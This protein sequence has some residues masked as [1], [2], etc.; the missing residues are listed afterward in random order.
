M[1][2]AGF[3]AQG[4]TT[5]LTPFS[6]DRREPGPDDVEIDIMYCG[7]CHSDLHTARNEWG[8]TVYPI[9]PGH[10]IIGRVSRT[11]ANATAF[12]EGDLLGVAC[13]VDSCQHCSECAEGLEQF[14]LNGST[15]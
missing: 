8:I 2:T 4:P 15:G 9:V 14:C 6:F 13:L 12:K 1:N 5:P 7:V 11:G 3:A 10:E